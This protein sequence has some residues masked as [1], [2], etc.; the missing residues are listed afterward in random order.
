M[1]CITTADCLKTYTNNE[2]IRV[3]SV[4][5]KFQIYHF[6]RGNFSF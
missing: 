5:E 6:K 2:H 1:E 4:F 3:P